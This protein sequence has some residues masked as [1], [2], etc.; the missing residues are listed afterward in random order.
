MT[1]AV[2]IVAGTGVCC[3]VDLV[4]LGSTNCYSSGVVCELLLFCCC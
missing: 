3:L 2:F 4:E 1:C